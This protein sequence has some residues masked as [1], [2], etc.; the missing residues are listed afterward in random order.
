MEKTE[1]KNWI[2]IIVS[3]ALALVLAVSAVLFFA[4]QGR[5]SVK[6]G[7]R[8]NSRIYIKN[9]RCENNV[10]SYTWYNGTS[11]EVTV[12]DRPILQ[13]KVEDKWVTVTVPGA[14]QETSLVLERFKKVEDSFK[15]ERW[16]GVAAGANRLGE[17]RLVEPIGT[18]T[19]PLYMVGYFT[20]EQ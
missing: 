12:S 6:D 14:E 3:A 10:I 20:M 19:E 11:K 13:K 7:L 2:F 15:V 4:M 1:K 16:L 8:Q 9:V 5:V 17:Y 18:E